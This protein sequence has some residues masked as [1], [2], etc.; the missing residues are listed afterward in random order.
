M[1]QLMD[2]FLKKL[3]PYPNLCKSQERLLPECFWFWLF[4]SPVCRW[5][6]RESG[7]AEKCSLPIHT[8]YGNH[9]ENDRAAVGKGTIHL[10]TYALVM[11]GIQLLM[12]MEGFQCWAAVPTQATFETLNCSDTRLD[13]LPGKWQCLIVLLLREFSSLLICEIGIIGL[14]S[15]C[16]FLF[17]NPVRQDEQIMSLCKKS[18]LEGRSLIRRIGH[19]TF[20]S[21]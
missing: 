4:R 1:I 3:F 17:K 12:W 5:G 6:R 18:A 14:C 2:V 15:T 20:F 16:F 7:K 19:I 13:S 10:P 21:P 8:V 11:K 9:L